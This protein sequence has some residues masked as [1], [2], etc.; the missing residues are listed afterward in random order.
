[1]LERDCRHELTAHHTGSQRV[2]ILGVGVMPIDLGQAVATL[3]RWHEE[4]RRDYV[5][6]VSVHGLVTAATDGA[7]VVRTG[8]VS[9]RKI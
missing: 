4:G 3:D 5:C 1:L 8:L 2:N 7:E 9:V 6:C